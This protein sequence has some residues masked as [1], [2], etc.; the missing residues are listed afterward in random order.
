[1]AAIKLNQIIQDLEVG[2]SYVAEFELD[3]AQLAAGAPVSLPDEK[4]GS[5]QGVPIFIRNAVLS[6]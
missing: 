3:E 1:M 5:Y 2:A 4:I 6:K